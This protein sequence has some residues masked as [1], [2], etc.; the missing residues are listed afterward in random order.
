MTTESQVPTSAAQS[1]DARHIWHPFTQMREHE[2]AVPAYVVR[3]QGAHLEL[4]DGTRVFDGIASWWTN[5]HGHSHPHIAAAIAHQA[6]TLDHVLFAGF[7]HGPATRLAEL[8][9]ERVDPSLHRFFFSDNGSTAIE[10]ALKMTFQ[11]QVLQGQA[12]RTR[13]GALQGAYHGDTLGAVGVGDLA[14]FVSSV[15]AP[16]LLRCDRLSMPADTRR[17]C[18]VPSGEQ[19]AHLSHQITAAAAEIEKYFDMCGHSLAAFIVEPVVQGAGG[20]FAWPPELLETLRECCT[21]H[22]V[23]LIFDEVM[24]GFGRTTT[25]FAYE[26]SAARPDVLCLSKGLTGGALPLA[27]TCATEAL[28]DVFLGDIA[29]KRAFLHGHSYTGNPIACAAAV[30]SLELFKQENTLANAERIADAFKLHWPMLGTL[31]TIRDSRLIGSIAACRWVD[32]RSGEAR[33][34]LAADGLTLH[35]LALSKGLLIR[36]IGDCL[37]LLPP[38]CATPGEVEQAVSTLRDCLSEVG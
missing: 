17:N 8:L 24:T 36:P 27:I 12:G 14:N 9:A 1:A 11:A 18:A 35:R 29:S 32:G 15:F 4:G 10:V 25:F 34:H 16:L 7:T 28:Y 20:M 13:I 3:G 23:Y 6:A 31:P 38:L 22:G 5:I 19:A 2:V 26:Q 37:Y 21:K 30:A 33:R